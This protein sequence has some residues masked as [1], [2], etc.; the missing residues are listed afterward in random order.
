M[1]NISL[2]IFPLV[3]T[4]KWFIQDLQ[5][6]TLGL[7]TKE[8]LY[9]L[10]ENVIPWGFDV[11]RLQMGL[12]QCVSGMTKMLWLMVVQC[13]LYAVLPRAITGQGFNQSKR[14]TTAP[15][16]CVQN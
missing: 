4:L 8:V 16:D 2:F 6:N 15:N 14:A 5:D 12:A 1:V 3:V 11:Q 10:L 13:V 7:D 9:V